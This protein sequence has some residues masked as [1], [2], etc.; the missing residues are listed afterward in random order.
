MTSFL[1]SKL[2]ATTMPLRFQSVRW[3]H[4]R[5]RVRPSP[6]PLII[7]RHDIRTP[8]SVTTA[9]TPSSHARQASSAMTSRTV[10]EYSLHNAMCGVAQDLS[11]VSPIVHEYSSVNIRREVN[12]AASD[13]LWIFIK[14]RAR[15][16]NR[17]IESLPRAATY[18]NIHL[19]DQRPPR[20][21]HLN[22][23]QPH[24]M[25]CYEQC[26]LWYRNCLLCQNA[27]FIASAA[28]DNL[29]RTCL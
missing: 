29:T 17:C 10:H 7:R 18:V 22:R 26:Q 4:E 28:G 16:P 20:V 2:D 11:T 9:T 21:P 25:G 8:G 13:L 12:G 6:I 1:I 27:Y 15:R 19:Y 24:R 5:S 3:F 14:C 23:R